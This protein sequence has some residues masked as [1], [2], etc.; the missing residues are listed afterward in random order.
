MIS[1]SVGI[2]TLL[3]GTFVISVVLFELGTII[4]IKEVSSCK[5][6]KA[7]YLSLS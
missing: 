5:I 7:T 1:K 3:I 2:K 4:R 6:K